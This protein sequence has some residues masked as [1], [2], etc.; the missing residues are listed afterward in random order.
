MI[1]TR[2]FILS[3]ASGISERLKILWIL[4]E[5]ENNKKLQFEGSPKVVHNEALCKISQV[6]NI[7]E[8]ARLF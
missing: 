2:K 1:L 7:N 4:G 6:G 5:N 3:L 8:V